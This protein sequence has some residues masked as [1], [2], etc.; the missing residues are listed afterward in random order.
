M[1]SAQ[2]RNPQR[3]ENHPPGTLA[4]TTDD[5][6]TIAPKAMA[7][8]PEGRQTIAQ[9]V[10]AGFRPT[11]NTQPREGRQIPRFFTHRTATPHS[12][13]FLTPASLKT[14]RRQ[15]RKASDPRPFPLRVFAPSREPSQ[16]W[17]EISREA[18][19][20]AKKGNPNTNA[21]SSVRSTSMAADSLALRNIPT[22]HAPCVRATRPATPRRARR[23]RDRDRHRYR[24]LSD[25]FEC[26]P[27]AR[28]S[29]SR[30]D[31]EPAEVG[32][33]LHHGFP[34]C[35]QKRCSN[36]RLRLRSRERRWRPSS[37]CCRQWSN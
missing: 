5:H 7:P 15:D 1:E 11:I 32:I 33:P 29:F 6:I 14:Q 34:G 30:R 31:A 23:Y 2:P 27:P 22:R 36:T 37:D 16:L 17:N 24:K 13:G 26:P 12:N 4:K 19:K 21:T 20:T 8:G 28:N 25:V 3:H 9:R 18:A 35:M 10:S